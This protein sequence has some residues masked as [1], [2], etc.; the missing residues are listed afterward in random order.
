MKV[1]ATFSDTEGWP[2][3]KTFS[4]EEGA[5]EY[6]LEEGI[7]IDGRLNDDPDY[8]PCD[9]WNPCPMLIVGDEHKKRKFDGFQ[10]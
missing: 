6:L 3:A 9:S 1:T 2:N 5:I 8:E 4:S 10:Y 7:N